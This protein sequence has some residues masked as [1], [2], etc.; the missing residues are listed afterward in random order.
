MFPVNRFVIV[1]CCLAIGWLVLAAVPCRADMLN[2]LFNANNGQAGNMFDTNVLASGG[3]RIEAL[4]LNLDP[5]DWDAE[6]WTLNG[7]YAGNETNP[8]VWTLRDSFSGLTSAGFDNPTAW[9]IVDFN[10]AAGA[11]AF[12]VRVSNGSGM[13]YTN[14]SSEGAL[15][16]EDANLQIF[17]GTGNAGFFGNQ[18]RPR[19]W[20]G[21]IMY[22][23]IPE[24][25]A[26]A[27]L[28]TG[29]I[30]MLLRRSSRREW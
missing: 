3:I 2:T 20:N 18:F 25:S 6:L 29:C 28:A 13:N 19:I 23:V 1:L 12:Y 11:E 17:Q 5:G 10:L 14:G 16:V 21:S 30:A 7:T 26:L 27:L 22:T 9:D 8:A 4:E 24:P 15:F